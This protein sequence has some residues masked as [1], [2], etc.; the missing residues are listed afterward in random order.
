MDRKAVGRRWMNAVAMS[1]PVPKCR[2]RNIN[3]RGIGSEGKRCARTGKAH[4][5][6]RE[7]GK[8]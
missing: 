4:A 5:T 6:S 2:E 1:T 7:C 8:H 3:R